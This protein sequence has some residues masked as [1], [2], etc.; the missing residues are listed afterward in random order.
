MPY[1]FIMQTLRS[2]FKKCITPL[3]QKRLVSLTCG[4]WWSQDASK[5]DIKKQYYKKAKKYHPDANKDDPQA[6]KKFSEATEAWEILGDDEKRGLYDN[7]QS[8]YDVLD[9]SV[10]L[11]VE[12][13][14]CYGIARGFIW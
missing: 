12:Q 8:M 14:F 9:R 2:R 4:S 6:A 1:R 13:D 5:N 7:P 10:C 3:R 11:V